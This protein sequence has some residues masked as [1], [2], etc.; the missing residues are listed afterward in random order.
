[1]KLNINN[2]LQNIQNTE[3]KNKP[4]NHL[5]ID[6]LLPDVFYKK[7][8]R[9]LQDEKFVNKYDR[10]PYGNK[11]RYGVDITDYFLWKSNGR[12]I[13]TTIHN[14]N[15]KCLLSGGNNN[16]KE[17]VNVLL[18]NQKQF[19]SLLCKKLPTERI[20][21]NYF[22]HINMTK[23]SV[24]YKIGPHTDDKE[25]IFTILFYVPEDDKNKKFGLQICD[26]KIDFIPNRMV[27]F[28]P[29]K[30]GE[31][32]PPTWHQVNCLTNDIIGT[33]NSFQMFF[34]KNHE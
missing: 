34:Y 15:Y 24:G 23:D 13:P 14:E 2:I 12:K 30:P 33:R 1:M 11:E 27:I 29:S 18:Q 28:A 7:L 20:Q 3:V 19:Y 26:Q 32:R 25:N 5:I 4:F 6:N 22:F 8:A 10:A 17:F 9:E 21:K 31:N 16:L